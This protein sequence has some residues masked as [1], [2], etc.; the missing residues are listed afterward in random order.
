MRTFTRRI[1]AI[2][3]IGCAA[4]AA[5]AAAPAAPDAQGDVTLPVVRLAAGIDPVAEL[6]PNRVVVRV[7]VDVTCLVPE[8]TT[9]YVSL[10]VTQAV[11]DAVAA[12]YGA[13]PGGVRC[14][15]LSHRITVSVVAGAGGA[16]F[17]AGRAAVSA[18]V[19]ACPEPAG[20]GDAGAC[21]FLETEPQDLLLL[22]K[23]RS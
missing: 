23:L 10:S 11:G 8:A 18:S 2:A 5:P 3:A 21:E 19:S 7:P 13:V 12:G 20:E 14:D 6:A 4:L 9:A 15:G 16:A 22:R 1:A 17:R